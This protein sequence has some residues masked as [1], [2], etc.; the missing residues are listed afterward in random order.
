MLAPFLALFLLGATSA[1]VAPPQPLSDQEVPRYLRGGELAEWSRARQMHDAG[2][3][4]VAQGTSI[5]NA[6]RT[7]SVGSG[8]ETPAEAKARGER[9]VKEGGEQIARA[10]VTLGRL[11]AN[12][13]NRLAEM[14]KTV[15]DAA[16]LPAQSWE[17]GLLL[18]AVRGVKS[19]RDA[20]C[21]RHHLLGAWSFDAQ[22]VPRPNPALYESFRAAWT[23]AQAE[24][25]LLQPIPPGGYRLGP[26]A[27][28]GD[29]PT[30]SAGWV[31]PARPGDIALAW[32]EIHALSDEASLVFLRVADARTLRLLASEAFLC[33]PSGAKPALRGSMSLRD[34]RSFLPRLATQPTW[35]LSYASG[36]PP[37]GAAVLR[38]LCYRLGH[39][40]V[41]ADD[42]LAGL[43]AGS[44][45]PSRANAA[46]EFRQLPAPAP[47]PGAK[48]A[49]APPAFLRSYR[50]SSAA[51]EQSVEV[52]EIT[53]RVEPDA[54][55]SGG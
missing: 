5:V 22:G 23:K 51:G 2:Q 14:T 12:A 9:M 40:T 24:R 48:P 35:R 34:D 29:P 13:A 7:Q 42:A 45:G 16:D 8:F 41:W 39:V 1:P 10:N 54:K 25:N 26:P 38:H 33:S 36:T 19:A 11:R 49:D 21:A 43:L 28:E 37:L 46:W 15:N 3:S 30:F 6:P 18:S 53:V 32:V 31:A 50:L 44:A 20:G 27:V 47:T 17:D 52:G 55:P 4:R